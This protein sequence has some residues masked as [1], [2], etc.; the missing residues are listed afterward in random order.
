MNKHQLLVSGAKSLRT[1]L[2]ERSGEIDSLRQLPQDLAEK[3]AAKGFYRICTPEK[4][5][6][7]AQDP[8]TL[9]EVCETLAGA[10]G[11][12]AWCVFIG[13]T[14]Q[15][16][17]GA[18]A[19]E[20]QQAMMENINVLTS[21]VFADSGTAQFEVRNNQPGYLINGHWRWGSGCHNAAWISGGIHEINEDG[22]PHQSTDS[23]LTRVFF[24]PD[25][26]E[27]LDNWRVS[28]LRGSG[29][30]DYRVE[31]VWVSALRMASSIE[32]TDLKNLPIYRY[33]KFALL[34][35][36]IGAITIGMA[37]ASIDEVIEIANQKTPQGSRRTL[38]HRPVLHKDMG[39]ADTK[40]AAARSY[41]YALSNEV[42]Q[43]CQTDEPTVEQ[44]QQL[45]AANVHA[46]NTAVE[47]ID[48]M[49]TIVGGTSVFETSCLQ[50]HFRDVHVATQHMMVAEPV[51]ELAGRVILG[52]DNEAPGL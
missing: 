8:A 11:S 46:V 33:P 43:H 15:Y 41:L 10:N 23:I 51:M 30:S 20:Q 12:A 49:Y 3:M 5:G 4:I 29:S 16:L 24:K 35:L 40:L 44:R 2:L 6:G 31:N 45:R 19:P 1:E 25:E 48:K 39:S 28:G 14:S 17:L 21:G 47:V 27:I 13:S 37:R 22:E 42:W 38:A 50:Q 34:S 9:Y 18:L 26:I 32:Q 36:P 7:L 52:L